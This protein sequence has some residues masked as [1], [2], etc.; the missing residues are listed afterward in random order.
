MLHDDDGS[1]NIVRNLSNNLPESL[2]TSSRS[3]NDDEILYRHFR[4]P[5]GAFW[6]LLASPQT[7]MRGRTFALRRLLCHV[8]PM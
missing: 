3:T 5:A 2:M 6:L 8:K 1:R 4:Q 7:I